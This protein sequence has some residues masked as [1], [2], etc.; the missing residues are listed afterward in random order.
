[1]QYKPGHIKQ[2]DSN[3]KFILSLTRHFFF[4]AS[5][6]LVRITLLVLYLL[7]QKGRD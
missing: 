1:M 7:P 5:G 6:K 3:D 4:G 2:S